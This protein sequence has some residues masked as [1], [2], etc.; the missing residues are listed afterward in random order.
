MTTVAVIGGGVLVVVVL[1]LFVIRLA[2]GEGRAKG[3]SE[4]AAATEQEAAEANEIR[5]SVGDLDGG[6]RERLLNRR[7]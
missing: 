3:I 4:G 6:E 7:D 2:K 5:D 1:I